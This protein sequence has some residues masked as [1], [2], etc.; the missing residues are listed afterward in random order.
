MDKEAAC[1]LLDLGVLVSFL[2]SKAVDPGDACV[3]LVVRVVFNF[4]GSDCELASR[5]FLGA[6][7]ETIFF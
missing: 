2:G 6:S 1:V 3:L 4:L 7:L 5:L